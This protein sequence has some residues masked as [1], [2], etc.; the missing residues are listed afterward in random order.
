MIGQNIQVY[1]AYGIQLSWVLPIQ[2]AASPGHT[3]F[4]M[5]QVGVAW[6]RGY[7]TYSYNVMYKNNI[8]KWVWP[9]DEANDIHVEQKESV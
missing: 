3:H 9:R 1:L 8:E 5:L 4:S 7:I 6:G 2:L